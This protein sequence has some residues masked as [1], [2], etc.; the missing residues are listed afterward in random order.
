MPAGGQADLILSPLS[1]M[2]RQSWIREN[3]TI[4]PSGDLPRLFPCNLRTTLLFVSAAFVGDMPNTSAAVI[5][6]EH[7]PVLPNG[8]TDRPAPHRIVI[9]NETCKE[10][11]VRAV[12][13][14]VM[15]RDTDHLVPGTL[16]AVPRAMLCRKAVA[17]IGQRKAPGRGIECHLER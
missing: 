13:L 8:D 6:D 4:G 17:V 12:G 16:F 1:A 11:L 7:T 5:G 15:H 3:V 2:W 9:H 10:I 14:S